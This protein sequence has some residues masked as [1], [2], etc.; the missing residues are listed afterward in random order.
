M[1]FFYICIMKF[2]RNLIIVL[3]LLVPVAGMAQPPLK[4]DSKRLVLGETLRYKAKWGMLTIGSA[5]A[6]TDR[7]LYKLGSVLCFKVNLQAQTNGVA[8]LFSLNDQWL[9]YIDISSITTRKSFRSIHEGNYRLE[10]I[11][12]F[13]HVNKNASV[14]IYDKTT[15]TYVLKHVYKTPKNIRDVVAGF[16]LIRLIDLS[17]YAK[18]DKLTIDGFYKAKG[19]SIDVIMAGKEY[20]KTDKGKLLCYKV[21]PIVPKNKTLDGLDAVDVWLTAD[22]KQIIVKA[23]AQL[24]FGELLIELDS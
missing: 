16:M 7:R 20:V 11:V 17:K 13:D 14:R 8:K 23:K 6:K 1:F 22:R 2:F 3:M 10:E 24:V 5:T 12:Y 4:F 15:K 9:S 18:G 21:K 19:Y